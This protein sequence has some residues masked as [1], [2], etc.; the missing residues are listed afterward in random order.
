[1][2]ELR[3]IADIHLGH[4]NILRY[5]NRPFSSIDEM[6]DAMLALWNETVK[7]DDVTYIL[8]DTTWLSAKCSKDWY[9]KLNGHKILVR[10]NHDTD[11]LL[12]KDGFGKCFDEIHDYIE[13]DGQG[14]FRKVILSHYPI[15]FF[16]GVHH[17]NLH[18]Y[19]HVHNSAQWNTTRNFR[20]SLEE[21]YACPWRMYNVGCMV[22]YVNYIPRTIAEIIEGITAEEP[23]NV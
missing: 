4:T 17:G 22:P 1:M 2:S 7:P 9:S 5:D 19:G 6:D 23:N 12:A 21:L 16:N 10:G 11:K 15:M 13:I 8:G 20:K 3:F 18:L 14:A